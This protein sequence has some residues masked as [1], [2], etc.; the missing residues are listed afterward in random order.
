MRLIGSHPGET[1]FTTERALAH[2]TGPSLPLASHRV[3]A[4]RFA[5][6]RTMTGAAQT[7]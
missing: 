6:A 7:K 4:P 5:G 1:T 3:K 2:S